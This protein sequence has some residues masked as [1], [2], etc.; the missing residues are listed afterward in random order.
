MEV[1]QLVDQVQQVE[2]LVDLGVEVG[3]QLEV[4]QAQSKEGPSGCHGG[5]SPFGLQAQGL[6]AEHE[7]HLWQ[8]EVLH[9]S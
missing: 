4:E 3:L 8:L 2:E 6:E 1:P 7:V 9:L 5:C